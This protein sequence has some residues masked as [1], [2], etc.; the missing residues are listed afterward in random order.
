MN[1][2]ALEGNEE[3][4]SI[5]AEGIGAA[6]V[7]SYCAELSEGLDRQRITSRMTLGNEIPNVVFLLIILMICG[8][9]TIAAPTTTAYPSNLTKVC[10]C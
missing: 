2:D 3:S 10:M 5:D 4:L 9:L 1:E 8:T 6:D 7:I